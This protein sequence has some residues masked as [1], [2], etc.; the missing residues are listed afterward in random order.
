MTS[1][2]RAMRLPKSERCS[3]LQAC[4]IQR[5]PR[6][7]ENARQPGLGRCYEVGFYEKILLSLSIKKT[8]RRRLEGIGNVA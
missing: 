7:L 4:S 6:H 2:V 1:G 3:P 5:C 8:A